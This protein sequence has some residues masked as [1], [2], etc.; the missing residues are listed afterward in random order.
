[1]NRKVVLFLSVL[2]LFIEIG[3][4]A[5]MLISSAQQLSAS[6]V[7]VATIFARVR[8]YSRPLPKLGDITRTNIVAVISTGRR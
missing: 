2:L 8:E 5:A 1:M 4:G 7:G 6:R 3:I